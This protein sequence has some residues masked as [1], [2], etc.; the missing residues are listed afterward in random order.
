MSNVLIPRREI[1]PG[2]R[3]ECPRRSSIGPHDA[4]VTH[5]DPVGTD[6]PRSVVSLDCGHEINMSDDH[7]LYM[8]EVSK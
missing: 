5:V 3:V 2:D 8:A 1:R 6:R 4:T 7:G